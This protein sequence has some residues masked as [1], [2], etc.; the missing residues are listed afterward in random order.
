MAKNDWIGQQCRCQLIDAYA[1][2]STE[3]N[4]DEHRSANEQAHRP[5]SLELPPSRNVLV[6]SVE[7]TIKIWQNEIASSRICCEKPMNDIVYASL[8]LEAQ[9]ETD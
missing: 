9:L 1:C 5:V 7:R 2:P 8:A 3:F 6:H 4:S